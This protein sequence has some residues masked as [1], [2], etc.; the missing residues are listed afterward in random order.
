MRF[1]FL[2]ATPFLKKGKYVSNETGFLWYQKQWKEKALSENKHL[3]Q[4]QIYAN[5]HE[6]RANSKIGTRFRKIK[7]ALSDRRHCKRITLKEHQQFFDGDAAILTRSLGNGK[8]INYEKKEILSF[9]ASEERMQEILEKRQIWQSFG[10]SV[11]EIFQIDEEHRF[12]IESLIEKQ[13]FSP[14]QGFDFVTKDLLRYQMTPDLGTVPP[15]SQEELAKKVEGLKKVSDLWGGVPMVID[16][17]QSKNYVRRICHG[18]MYRNNLMFDGEKF[19]YI[20]FELL[21]PRVFFLDVMFY[22][23]NEF[24]QYNNDTLLKNFFA[25]EYDVYLKDLFAANHSE[26]DPS[27]KQVYYFLAL[28]EYFCECFETKIPEKLLK[29]L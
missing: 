8:I 26:F 13:V 16:F 24:L 11:P 5:Q 7:Q 18:D 12:L 28:Y 25:G 14:E 21:A 3:I 22:M 15:L 23:T 10:F 29:V 9:F 17:V 20:D 6:I 4:Q 27:L 1:R 19:Y 2:K